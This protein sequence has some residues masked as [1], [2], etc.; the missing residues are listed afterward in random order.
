MAGDMLSDLDIPEVEEG[1]GRRIREQ[2]MDQ[3]RL[4]QPY[5]TYV[6]K[7]GQYDN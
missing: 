2:L 3:L 1:S 5:G 4:D 7:G 6:I